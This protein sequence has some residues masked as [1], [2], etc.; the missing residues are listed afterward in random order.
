[1]RIGQHLSQ[2]ITCCCAAQRFFEA[3]AQLKRRPTF[4]RRVSRQV[5]FFRC[6]LT[7]APGSNVQPLAS[8]AEPEEIYCRYLTIPLLFARLGIG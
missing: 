5:A 8:R 2:S 4:D 6:V 1:V 3:I 7:V